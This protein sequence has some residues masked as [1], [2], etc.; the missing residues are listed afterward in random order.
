[1]NL[2]TEDVWTVL[3]FSYDFENTIFKKNC[4]YDHEIVNLNT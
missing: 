4:D 1:M 2:L 3:E